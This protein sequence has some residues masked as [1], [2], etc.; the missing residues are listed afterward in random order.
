[1]NTNNTTCICRVRYR[2]KSLATSYARLQFRFELASFLSRIFLDVRL[3]HVKLC[4]YS[5]FL[6]FCF[7]LLLI[8][9]TPV[10]TKF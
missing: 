9:F 5:T 6:L 2:H 1:M 7:I 3:Y 8:Y 4:S 10:F